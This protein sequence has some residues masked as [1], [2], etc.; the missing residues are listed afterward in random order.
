[1]KPSTAALALVLATLAGTAAAVDPPRPPEKIRNVT[2]PP[3][4]PKLVPLLK[5]PA[6]PSVAVPNGSYLATCQNVR[7]E[8]DLL[9]ASCSRRNGDRADTSI[10]VSGCAGVDIFNR[11]G[12]L[13]CVTPVRA[14]WA[15][16]VLPPGSYVAT[17][18]AAVE[19]TT[20]HAACLTGEGDVS[21]L[22]M[23]MVREGVREN[24]LDLTRCPDG[25]EIANLRGD[26]TCVAR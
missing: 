14:R 5:V 21:I 7:V 11:N 13:M 18:S 24:R 22:G 17:C 26:L 20:L 6:A 9:K 16:L 15:G 4:A 3:P 1:M 10:S 19:G 25:S 12:N 2:P 23:D 8:G